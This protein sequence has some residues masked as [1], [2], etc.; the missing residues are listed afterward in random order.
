MK[1]ILAWSILVC[2]AV[3]PGH[4]SPVFAGYIQSGQN[5]TFVLTDT[6]EAG[7]SG[8]LTIGRSFNG[9]ALVAFDHSA[10]TLSL[11]KGDQTLELSL[12]IAR[13]ADADAKTKALARDLEAARADLTRMLLRFR[14]KH[15]SVIKQRLKVADLARQLAKSAPAS[16]ATTPDV[17]AK[18]V[19]EQGSGLVP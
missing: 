10:E 4:A 3:S 18:R 11:R 7:S 16:E 1:S 8:W 6:E 12:K 13:V 17:P 15:P 9:Y 19:P 14:E 5:Y 2:A